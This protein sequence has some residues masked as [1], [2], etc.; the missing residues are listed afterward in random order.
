MTNEKLQSTL[1]LDHLFKN[2]IDNNLCHESQANSSFIT[3]NIIFSQSCKN[4]IYLFI[5]PFLTN[6]LI[7]VI[8]GIKKG[9]HKTQALPIE[10]ALNSDIFSGR[11][12]CKLRVKT[13]DP[14][15][16]TLRQRFP[17]MR[18]QGAGSGQVPGGGVRGVRDIIVNL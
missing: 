7:I 6:F 12:F 9:V 1:K 3:K 10:T 14:E 8:Q 4:F 16:Q 13:P 11:E 2:I 18:T 5:C 17:L 15:V